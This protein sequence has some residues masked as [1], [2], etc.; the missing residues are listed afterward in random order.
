VVILPKP[1]TEQVVV[2]VEQE[3]VLLRGFRDLVAERFGYFMGR[4]LTQQEMNEKTEE[5]RKAVREVRKS[6]NIEEFIQNSD[7]EGYKGK[8]QELDAA[9]NVVKEKSKPFREKISPL[10]KAIRFLDNVAIPDALKE[11]GTPVQPR[12]SISDY[13]EKQLAQQKKK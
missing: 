9:R 7:L 11:L 12:F 2:E 1:K 8:L 5:E 13:I 6:I 4:R 3:L 10:G